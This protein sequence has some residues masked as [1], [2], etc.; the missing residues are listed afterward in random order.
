[1]I[2]ELGEVKDQMLGVERKQHDVHAKV[3][4]LSVSTTN[5]ILR[6]YTEVLK[7]L[8]SSQL[9]QFLQKRMN[10]GGTCQNIIYVENFL[11]HTRYA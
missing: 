3:T 2:A 7:V 9:L 11:F 10:K 4:R 6:I 8:L 1:M 5:I